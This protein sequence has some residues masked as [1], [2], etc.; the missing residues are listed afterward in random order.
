MKSFLS[1]FL[2]KTPVPYATQR[3]SFAA[4]KKT[5][6]PGSQG[7]DAY[8][9]VGT[10]HAIVSR[11]ANSTSQVDWH[12]YRKTTDGRR[13]YATADGSDGRT[14]VT[15]HA[16]L[17][18]LNK[19]NPFMPRQ[20]FIEVVQQHLDLTG[21]G[22]IVVSKLKGTNIPYELWPVRPDKMSIVKDANDFL[23][24]YVYTGP[25]G[26][27]I[28][29]AVEDVIQLRYPNPMDMYRGISPVQAIMVDLESDRYAAEWNRNFF[30]NN[31]IPGAVIEIP[32]TLTD[33]EFREFQDRWRESHQ[34][35]SNAHRV[36][37][38]E[39][40]GKFVESK[41]AQRDMQ[42]AE[43][44]NVSSDAIR[45]AFGYPKPM[46]GD[47]D[48]VNLANAV[49]GE[50]V[51]AKWLL[52]SRLERWKAMLI[53]DLLPMFGSGDLEFDYD[54][55]VPVDKKAEG[56]ILVG[57]AAAVAALVA[58]GYDPAGVLEVV[59]LPPIDWKEPP[60][61]V[62]PIAPDTTS[63]PTGT[64]TGGGPDLKSGNADTDNTN[65]GGK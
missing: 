56:E 39:Y 9:K 25:D 17:D 26:E 63:G 8:G 15:R 33:T 28:P 10:L 18:L 12:L 41:F 59:G 29:L 50:Y 21:E 37:I 64:D 51:F 43:L 48:D 42:F 35:V 34:G 57:Q 47:T 38:I 62:A 2:N 24:G 31:A 60:K 27:K 14:E 44:R 61:P 7:L 16:A 49:A 52:V 19:P 20:E 53:N 45:R 3:E 23:T 54:S 55:P 6:S 4:A 13:R 22:W 46:L 65:G 11:L 58:A 30:K 40:G 32:E 1:A 36:G 5:G